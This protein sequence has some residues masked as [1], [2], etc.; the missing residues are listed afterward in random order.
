M[1]KLNEPTIIATLDLDNPFDQI[2][3]KGYAEA[4]RASGKKITAIGVGFNTLER[5][6]TD[7]V[8]ERL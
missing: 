8:E 4:H 5:E 1:A 2:K 3:K 7:W 6:I